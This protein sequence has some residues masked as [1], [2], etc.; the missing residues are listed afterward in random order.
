MHY[1]Y[2]RHPSPATSKGVELG[3]KRDAGL[4]GASLTEA[5]RVETDAAPPTQRLA[6]VRGEV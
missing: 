4:G 3:V 1:I 6:A 2:D 5:D